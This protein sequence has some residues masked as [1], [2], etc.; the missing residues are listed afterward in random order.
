MDMRG[1]AAPLDRF[2]VVV[3]CLPGRAPRPR[4]A[5]SLNYRPF[6]VNR[7]LIAALVG[8]AAFSVVLPVAAQSVSDRLSRLSADDAGGRAEME[9]LSK[10]GEE[11]ALAALA[12]LEG[13]DAA[14][15]GVLGR[16]RRAHVVFAAGGARCVAGAIAALADPDEGTRAELLAF[17]GRDDLGTTALRERVE[18]LA[19]CAL[20]DPDPALRSR[21]LTLLASLDRDESLARLDTLIDELEEPLRVQAALLLA[22]RPRARSLLSKRV[23]SLDPALAPLL[24]ALGRDLGDRAQPG[25]AGPIFRGIRSPDPRTRRGAE[26]G[27]DSLV[28]RLF[29]GADSARAVKALLEL[30]DLGLDRGQG[31]MLRARAVLAFGADPQPALAAA[32][33]LAAFAA[34]DG[35]ADARSTL[36][37]A[38][39]L[40]AAALIARGDAQQAAAPIAEEA[41]LLDGL[42]AERADRGSKNLAALQATRLHR[43]AQCEVLSMVR[44]LAASGFGPEKPLPESAGDPAV[45]PCLESARAA[46]ALELEAEIAEATARA[47][48]KSSL[49]GMFDDELSPVPLFLENPRLA[50]WPAPRS[51]WVRRTIGRMFSS[52]ARAEMPGFEPFADVPPATSDPLQ[53]PGRLARLRTLLRARRDALESRFQELRGRLRGEMSSDPTVP[54]EEEEHRMEGLMRER[55]DLLDTLQRVSKDDL[56]ALLE[57]RAPSLLGLSLARALRDDGREEEARATAYAVQKDLEKSGELKRF[58]LVEAELEMTIGST[59]SDSG[60]PERA[61]VEISRAADRLEAI[62]S[63]VRARGASLRDLAY[64]RGLRASALVSL[65]VNANVKRNDPKKALEYFEKAF[66]LRQ[67]EFMRVLLAC[68]RARSGRGDEARA[69]LREIS[70]SP[71]NL[72][73]VACTWAL[74]GEK[75]LALECLRRDLEENPMSEG[76][77]AKQRE[78]AKRDPD[79]ASLRDDPRFQ[80]IVGK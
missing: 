13:G 16:R 18:A 24:A 37:V 34:S 9:A 26:L 1:P 31:A 7:A 73:N 29:A 50:A 55:E 48:A 63:S 77:R 71:A 43:R 4:G 5:E 20:A 62:E 6:R 17:L 41:S 21:A 46:H 3:E 59:W 57:F 54:S 12:D 65:A 64:V 44:Q 56:Q 70:P 2:S 61:E 53:D 76:A 42:L 78:W 32:A 52:V 51:L 30:E 15:S 23:G 28:R 19:G 72:Y 11:A 33:D 66:E 8:L 67:D 49:D 68:Y 14:G 38:R 36:A 40:E 69:I 58:L 79:L 47:T 39:H 22:D 45:A 35:D 60:D 75:E 10:M 27:L 25:Q 80:A 74:L